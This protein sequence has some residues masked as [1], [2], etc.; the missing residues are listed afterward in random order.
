MY[1]GQN[2]NQ[3]FFLF[4]AI[5]L[6]FVFQKVF[7]KQSGKSWKGETQEGSHEASKRKS[8]EAVSESSSKEAR[9]TWKTW[10]WLKEG[11]FCW[12]S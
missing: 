10:L 8:D 3:I 7:D 5:Y 11:H 9:V 2:F 1:V 6:V 4:P 12:K